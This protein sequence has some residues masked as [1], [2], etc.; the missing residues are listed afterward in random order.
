VSY[1]T[2]GIIDTA[3]AAP[4]VSM[5]PLRRHLQCH[6]HRWGGSSGVID[7]AG[8]APAVL[9]TPL[10]RCDFE[11]SGW[12]KLNPLRR[13]QRC[14][15]T[16]LVR[17]QRCQW[18]CWGGTRGVID[19]AEAAPAESFLPL[20]RHQRSHSYRWGC[21]SG[22]NDTAGAPTLLNNLANSKPY[23]KMF[24]PI[25]G[26]GG[27]VWWKKPEVKNLVTLSL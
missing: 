25:G 11:P 5:T 10:V 4:G 19:T 13:D 18:H 14:K 3:E 7:T 17:H 24:Q 22:F 12:S 16:Q 2:S 26:P 27:I 21:S 8:A 9:L 23:A 20:R 6:W 1:R 15:L